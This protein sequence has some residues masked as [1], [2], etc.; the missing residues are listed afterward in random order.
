[1]ADKL[2]SSYELAMERLR[3]ADPEAGKEKPPTAAQKEK[4]AE[5]RRVAAARLAEVEIRFK[6]ASTRRVDPA[7]QEKA[8]A[9]YRIDRQRINTDLERAIAE[10]RSGRKSRS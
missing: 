2:K 4:I 8:E 9:E 7:E 1:M 3:G 5:A 6:D 10:I